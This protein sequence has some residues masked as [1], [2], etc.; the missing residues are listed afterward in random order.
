MAAVGLGCI[1]VFLGSLTIGFY[2]FDFKTK[3][4]AAKWDVLNFYLDV[5]KFTKTYGPTVFTNP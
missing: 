1:R 2:H 5:L 4:G 3:N